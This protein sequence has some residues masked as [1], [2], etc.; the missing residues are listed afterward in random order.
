[1]WQRGLPPV[2]NRHF[3]PRFQDRYAEATDGHFDLHGIERMHSILIPDGHTA[4]AELV[5]ESYTAHLT[6]DRE[7]GGKMGKK[8]SVAKCANEST[9]LAQLLAIPPTIA[10]FLGF[11]LLMS[12]TMTFF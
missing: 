4:F 2:K 12:S 3:I 6:R 10:A 11:P 1:M 8:I 5:G 7:N 9:D